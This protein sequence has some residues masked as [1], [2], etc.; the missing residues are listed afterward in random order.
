MSLLGLVNCFGQ[1]LEVLKS[2][3]IL[4]DKTIGIDT[5]ILDF[6]TIIVW[7]LKSVVKGTQNSYLSKI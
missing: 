7:K 1:F 6:S 3:F 2:A 4:K 5:R